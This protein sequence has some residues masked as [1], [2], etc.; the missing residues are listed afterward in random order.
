MDS[1]TIDVAGL[2]N[3]IAV[4]LARQGKMASACAAQR[5]ALDMAPQRADLQS[6]YGNMLRRRG[7]DYETAWQHLSQALVLDSTH[8]HAIHNIGVYLMER[9]DP[10]SALM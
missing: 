3:D 7:R 6:N 1:Q 5:R 8:Q 9:G 2:W 10:A 4:E